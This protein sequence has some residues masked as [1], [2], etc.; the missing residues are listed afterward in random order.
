MGTSYSTHGGG[1]GNHTQQTK[2][3]GGEQDGYDPITNYDS[4]K[5]NTSCYYP[6]NKRN[7]SLNKNQR[8]YLRQNSRGANKKRAT[9]LQIEIPVRSKQ[10]SEKV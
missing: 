6:T 8:N 3:I 5:V 9:D 7:N 4:H 1:N 10:L 2:K